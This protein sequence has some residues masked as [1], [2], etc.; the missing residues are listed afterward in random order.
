MLPGEYARAYGLKEYSDLEEMMAAE[1]LDAVALCTRHTQHAQWVQR[2]ARHGKDIFIA[3]TFVTTLADADRIL[4]AERENRIRIAVGPSARFLPWFVAAK[5]ALDGGRIGV[6]FSLRIC[7][8]HGTIDVFHPEDFY[9]EPAEGGP[10]LSLGWYMVDLVLQF[11]Q[12][13]VE[14]VSANYGT[15][16]TPGSPFMDCGKLSLCMAGGALAS[17]DMYFCNRFEFPSWE[18]ELVGEKGA[19]LVR[20]SCGAGKET[21]VVLLTAGGRK[22][23]SLPAR[24]PHWELFWIDELRG[25]GAPSLTAGYAREVTRVC[26]A[27]RDS[28]RRGKTVVL[29]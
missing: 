21:S 23:L 7:H 22:Q 3:K 6:P 20:Q 16:T 9:R 29:R 24:A 4:A 19:L 17:C 18:M 5:K 1:D 28:A 12:R 15:F 25:S 14:R 10:E 8:H 13:P 27:A 26:L 11:L 2:V